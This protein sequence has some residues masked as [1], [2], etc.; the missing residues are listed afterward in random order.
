[1]TNLSCALAMA[2]LFVP[3]SVSAQGQKPRAPQSRASSTL[4]LTVEATDKSGNSLADV[5]VGVT[6]PVDRKG[7]T[8]QKGAIVF[9]SMR[10]G[11]Y[12][13]R[14]EREGFVTLE[15]ELV[16]RA[17]QPASVSVALSAAPVKPVE[18]PAPAPSHEPEPAPRSQRVVEPRT[19]SLPDFLD[20]NLIGG[21]EPQKVTL[22]GCA[23]GGT[24]RLLQVRDPLTDQQHA[25]VD[26]ILYVVAGGGVV[27]IRNQDTKVSPGHF[28]L[29]PRGIPHGIRRDGR[30]PLILLSIFA[31]TPCTE[32][33]APEK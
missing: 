31:G 5:E 16:I 8:E 32:T 19:L 26:E 11:T 23:E 17:G 22:L 18:A 9:R 27:R 6:G 1:M 33:A 2:L 15:R 4:T 24:V 28:A 7:T 13:I 29:V 14:F 21:E 25:D 10:S 3:P 20:E 30:N 12:R